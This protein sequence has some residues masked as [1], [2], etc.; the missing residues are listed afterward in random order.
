MVAPPWI[1]QWICFLWSWSIFGSPQ[2]LVIFCWLVGGWWCSIYSLRHLTTKGLVSTYYPIWFSHKMF[3]YVSQYSPKINWLMVLTILKNMS[4][5]V[6][7]MNFPIYYGKIIQMFQT[8]NHIKPYRFW[9]SSFHQ[10]SGVKSLEQGDVVVDHGDEGRAVSAS[11]SR[12]EG[13]VGLGGFSWEAWD[14]MGF[15]YDFMWITMRKPNVGGWKIPY[16]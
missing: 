13:P 10:P 6:G 14:F 5:S 7:I 2:K 4:S 11:A 3:Q 1:F 9:F 16:L 8:T 12:N 15:L